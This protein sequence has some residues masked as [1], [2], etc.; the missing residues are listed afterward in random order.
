MEKCSTMKFTHLHPNDRNIF[1]PNK[2]NLQPVNGMF[3]SSHTLHQLLKDGL[4]GT[5][6]EELLIFWCRPIK[7]LQRIFPIKESSL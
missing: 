5:V 4:Q 3:L 1:S 2:V 6:T 7:F